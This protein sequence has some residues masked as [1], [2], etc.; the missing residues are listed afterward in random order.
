MKYK[1]MIGRYQPWH[2]G[3]Q[4][5]LDEL[6][7][8]SEGVFIAV[9]DCPIDENNPYYTADVVSNIG[10]WLHENRPQ[11][12][13]RII[14]S[15]IPNISGVHYGRGVGWEIVEHTPPA[16]IGKVSATNIRNENKTNT[17]HVRSDSA[18]PLNDGAR[19]YSEEEL[20]EWDG[21]DPQRNLDNGD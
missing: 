21:E 2:K 13:H 3:H 20:S 7:V 18:G 14:V 1:M 10:R 19:I 9:R 6:L 5:L 16:D 17:E 11:S 4:W 8:D 15:T 12:V